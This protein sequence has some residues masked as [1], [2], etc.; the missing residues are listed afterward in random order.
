MDS[1][2][3]GLSHFKYDRDGYPRIAINNND[4]FVEVHQGPSATLEYRCGYVDGLVTHFEAGGRI[5]KSGV[6]NDGYRPAVAVNGNT[7]IEM[8]DGG[9][10]GSLW[11]WTGSIN[12][13]NYTITWVTNNRYDSGESPTVAVDPNGI[14]VEV[15]T[16][17][18]LFGAGELW[19]STFQM[20]GTNAPT[21]KFGP[22]KIASDGID[23]TRATMRPSPS[24][25]GASSWKC[26]TRGASAASAQSCGIG[27]ASCRAT[28]RSNGS[29]TTNTMAANTRR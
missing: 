10:N 15:H 20:N 19:Y 18:S 6:G 26:T 11:Y 1:V 23:E 16:S 7:V 25:I 22:A 13:A 21:L 2:F 9:G 14:I 12:P 5:E 3:F 4:V 17:T 27:S 8:H 29:A 24:T 28:N